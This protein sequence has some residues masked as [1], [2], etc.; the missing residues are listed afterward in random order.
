MEVNEQL[1]LKLEKLSR[2]KLQAE[3]RKQMQSSLQQVLAMVDKLNEVNTEGIEPLTH[4]SDAVN[5]L[6]EDVVLN[7]LTNEQAMQ[8]APKT[9]D[10]YF[11]VPKFV[12]KE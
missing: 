4:I 10:N 1:I 9:M 3:E 8:N 12:H 7:Q 6:R 5:V 2:L 11:A